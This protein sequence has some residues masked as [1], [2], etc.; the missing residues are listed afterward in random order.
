MAELKPAVCRVAV[1]WI[2]G[3]MGLR[4]SDWVLLTTLLYT[5]LQI[6]FLVFKWRKEK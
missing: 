3:L 1:A 4:L 6:A 2:G 5:V